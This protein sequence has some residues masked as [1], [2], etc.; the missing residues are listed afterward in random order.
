MQ[1]TCKFC[2][3]RIYKIDGKKRLTRREH[4]FW[5]SLF[6]GADDISSCIFSKGICSMY[7]NLQQHLHHGFFKKQ[8]CGDSGLDLLQEHSFLYSGVWKKPAETHI[9]RYLVNHMCIAWVPCKK[10]GYQDS[11]LEH[12]QRDKG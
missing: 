9:A 10:F 7:R 6:A 11:K 12:C 5:K 2:R 3:F 1:L 4:R 8:L